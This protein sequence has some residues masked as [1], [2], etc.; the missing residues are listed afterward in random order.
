MG[1]VLNLVKVNS[2]V[3][4]Y[5]YRGSVNIGDL[6]LYLNKKGFDV[7]DEDY[8]EVLGIF[9]YSLFDNVLISELTGDSVDYEE[10]TEMYI[11]TINSLFKDYYNIDDESVSDEIYMLFKRS[12]EIC[13]D[14][15]DKLR[16]RLLNNDVPLKK[17][18]GLHI[19]KIIFSDD[20]LN[21]NCIYILVVK[22]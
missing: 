13:L 6:L 19:E 22:K 4:E 18:I 15:I 3:D 9:I 11:N 21:G 16:T 20:L 2:S 12:T 8:M 7:N 17:I 1:V 14:F 10:V 5:K